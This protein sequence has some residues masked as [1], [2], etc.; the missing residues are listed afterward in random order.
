MCSSARIAD[1]SIAG[2]CE[3]VV[4]VLGGWEGVPR[5]HGMSSCSDV[6]IKHLEKHTQAVHSFPHSSVRN[7]IWHLRFVFRRI[8]DKINV[9]YL[10]QWSSTEISFPFQLSLYTHHPA[11]GV[12]RGR[13]ISSCS[14]VSINA[15]GKTCVG[16]SFFPSQ[17]GD[18]SHLAL[19]FVFQHIHA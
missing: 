18:K 11:L 12:P 19:L 9:R 7:R 17:L 1:R 10:L 16:S 8:Y 4:I 6:S 2:V 3:H 15:R 13:G 14:H 5:G